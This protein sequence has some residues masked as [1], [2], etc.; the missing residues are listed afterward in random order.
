M[1]RLPLLLL[2]PARGAGSAAADFDAAV[3]AGDVA[4]VVG[5]LDAGRDVE[6]QSMGSTPLLRAVA[7]RRVA[8]ARALLDRGA[9]PDVRGSGMQSPLA[10]AARCAAPGDD[11]ATARCAAI[12][13]A[14]V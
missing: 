10:V 7:H 13:E 1:R 14:L 9:D 5:H 11:H 8:V 2:L 6:G 4:A 3:R 12:A